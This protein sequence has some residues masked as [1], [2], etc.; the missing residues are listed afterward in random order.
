MLNGSLQPFSR[1]RASRTDAARRA[2]VKTADGAKRH[3]SS[4]FSKMRTDLA[5]SIARLRRVV[6]D[7]GRIRSAQRNM[8]CRTTHEHA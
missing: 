1:V 5:R 4:V 8:W 6:R 7:A 2:I 3:I